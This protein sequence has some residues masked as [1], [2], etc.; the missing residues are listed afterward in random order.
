MIEK[1]VLRLFEC[2]SY[3]GFEGELGT[4]GELVREIVG[5]EIFA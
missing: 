5:R 1:E 3:G 2:E 4:C